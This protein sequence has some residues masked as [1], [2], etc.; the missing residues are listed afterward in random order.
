MA[1]WMEGV[2]RVVDVGKERVTSIA[3]VRVRKNEPSRRGKREGAESSEKQER[4]CTQWFVDRK[5]VHKEEKGG[6]SSKGLRGG[7]NAS[8]EGLQ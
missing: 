7:K 5:P 4:M 6:G 2:G 3:V 8:G 1:E